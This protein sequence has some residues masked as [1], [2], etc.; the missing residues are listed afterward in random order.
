MT[1][2]K[3]PEEIYP[4]LGFRTDDF[5]RLTYRTTFN[6]DYEYAY[7]LGYRDGRFKERL[8]ASNPRAG[9]SNLTEAIQAGERV[10][11]ERLDGLEAKCVHPELGALTY[12]MERNIHFSMGS[13]SG[14]CASD[15][16]RM[17][18]TALYNSWHGEGGWSLWVKGDL[19]LRK[20]TADELEPG[21]CF[22]ARFKRNGTEHNYKYAQLV[23]VTPEKQVVICYSHQLVSIF[24]RH[25]A[26]GEVE[27]IEVYGIATFPAPKEEA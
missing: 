25:Y 5:G 23:N 15:R 2:K 17:W 11:W 6:S 14:W 18:D 9:W 3:Y 12:K 22:R 16:P 4:K 8:E 10:D 27:A 24:N 1:E 7:D 19:P 26:P 20:R 13:S 21:T